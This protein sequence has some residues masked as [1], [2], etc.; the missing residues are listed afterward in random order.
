M[1]LNCLF[2][3]R[4]LIGS[5]TRTGCYQ[6][7]NKNYYDCTA[8]C[9]PKTKSMWRSYHISIRFESR[10]LFHYDSF[11]YFS[12]RFSK[13]TFPGTISLKILYKFLVSSASAI[14]PSYIHLTVFTNIKKR[15]RIFSLWRI[16]RKF[17][18]W[19][20]SLR[21]KF[22]SEHLIVM[23]CWSKGSMCMVLYCTVGK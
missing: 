23:K 8:L 9:N 16:C 22:V 10:N 5:L 21:F 13:M 17:N 15:T 11:L 18:I 1:L 2:K 19:L 20:I 7:R 3:L 4:L 6:I 14:R 12:T